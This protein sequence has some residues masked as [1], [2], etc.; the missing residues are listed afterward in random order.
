MKKE[1]QKQG[2]VQQIM[3]LLTDGW[4][5]SRVNLKNALKAA[6]ADL[7]GNLILFFFFSMLQ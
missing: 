2:D 5:N 7:K 6:K 3:I 1:E 4:S